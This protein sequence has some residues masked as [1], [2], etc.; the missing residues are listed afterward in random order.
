VTKIKALELG[1]GIV[2]AVI[3]I[4]IGITAWTNQAPSVATATSTATGT[5]LANAGVT[6]TT[7][8]GTVYSFVNVFWALGALVIVG[9]LAFRYLHK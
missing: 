2:F 8:A 7:L 9:V 1:I 6:S 3:G 4:V 5:A